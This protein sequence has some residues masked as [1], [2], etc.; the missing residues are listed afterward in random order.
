VENLAG[1][2]RILVSNDDGIHSEGLRALVDSLRCLGEVVAVAPDREQSGV[3]H[4]L[5][6]HRPL[7]LRQMDAGFYA[8]DGTPTDC[9]LLGVNRVFGGVVPDLV[10]SGINKGGNLGDD[11]VYSGT[12]SA[13]MEG[14]R[15]GIPSFAISLASRSD[16]RFEV[17]AR[18]ARR[19]AQRIVQRSCKGSLLL[20]VNVPNIGD[21][22]IRGVRIT[23]QGKRVYNGAVVEKIDP[24]GEKY[25]W[26]G[27]EEPGFQELVDS[28][29]EAVLNGW[30]SITPL[31]LDLTDYEA[32]ERLRGW[33]I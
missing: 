3:S 28:D 29:I 25:Y 10:I 32:I 6:M 24:R 17:A 21:E 20:N 18:F 22:E 27:G 14:A 5:T 4:S 11:I 9:I 12:V 16:F 8:V 15:L 33:E 26:I 1:M 2:S 31:K 13:A 7:R 19:L 23:R 30:I